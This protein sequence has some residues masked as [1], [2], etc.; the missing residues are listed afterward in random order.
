MRSRTDLAIDE[1]ERVSGSIPGVKKEELSFENVKITRITVENSEGAEAIGKPVGRYITVETES[2][3]RF[4]DMTDARQAAVTG[5]LS[6]LL[7]PDGAVLV[8][9][10]G[11]TEIT[12]DAVGP[13]SVGMIL[14]TRHLSGEL[15]RKV[16]LGDLR[17]VSALSP[18]VL[19]KTGI[20]TGELLFGVVRQ[21][22]PAAVIVIDALAS[23][24]LSRLGRTVQI[25]DTGIIPGSGVGNA[26]REISRKT[27]GV[28]VIA[29][30]VPTVVDA[31]TLARDVF[32]GEE[33]PSQ[34]GTAD[35]MVTPREIDTVVENA[36]ALIAL[37]VNRALHPAIPAEE[38]MALVG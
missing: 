14:A 3:G 31:V 19:G 12:P 37:S 8:A 28:P 33:D 1:H 6:R 22:A 9:G 36:A 7:P 30:G 26:R 38:L 17:A 18:G 21:I 16:G 13:R 15:T 27:L 24:S 2:F 23:N 5:E 34:N 20:E 25:T 4:S 10:L 11:N 29:V 32:K 35:M